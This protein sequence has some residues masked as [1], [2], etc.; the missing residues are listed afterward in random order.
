MPSAGTASD[1]EK[2]KFLSSGWAVH[3]KSLA[4]SASFQF[5]VGYFS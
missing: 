3:F 4:P 1:S 2:G 5:E